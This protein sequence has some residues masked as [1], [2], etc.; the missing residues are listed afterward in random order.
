MTRGVPSRRLMVP[1]D[2]RRLALPGLVAAAQCR[3]VKISAHQDVIGE[4]NQLRAALTGGPSSWVPGPQESETATVVE[5]AADTPFG[6]LSQFARLEM[7]TPELHEGEV[8][9]P[10]SWVALEGEAFFP[11]LYG[12]LG[13]KLV[14]DGRSEL[15]L[16]GLYAPPMG[17]IGQAADVV[18]MNAVAKA[19]VE[20]FVQRVAGVLSRNALGRSV[21]EQVTAGRLTLDRDS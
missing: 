17:L 16:R 20:D 21:D 13:L 12:E 18:M 15:E 10:I 5:L 7:G 3:V 11:T 2:A 9:L 1:M 14:A 8:I 4:F 19:T 6:R